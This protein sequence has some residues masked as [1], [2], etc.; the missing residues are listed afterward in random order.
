MKYQIFE[1]D[2]KIVL[3]KLIEDGVQ[4]DAVVTDPPYGLRFMNRKWDYD[5][6]SVEFWE[7]VLKIL[8][9]GGHVLSFGGTRTYH[10]MVVN[11]EDA[12]FEIRDQIVWMYG[13]GFPKSM[14]IG[15]SID[16]AAG[17][18]RKIVGFDETRFRANRTYEGGAKHEESVEAV[19]VGHGFDRRDNGATIT[20]PAT[21]EAI[22]WQGW[23]TALKPAI[24]PIVLARKPLEEPTVAANV[25]K[26]GT[27]G[28]NIDECRVKTTD[29]LGGGATSSDKAVIAIEGFDRPWMHDETKLK[30][31]QEKM[32]KNVV[33]AE[34]LGRFPA[35][36]ILDEEAGEM[37]DE[38]T[39]IS[40]SPTKPVKQGGQKSV[41]GIMNNVGGPRHGFGTG[42]G[43]SGDASRFFYC[44][45][46]SKKDRR[47][48]KHPTIKP[49]AL[50]RYLCRLITPPGGTVLDP[51]AGSGTTGEA[52]A[53]E[54]FQSILIE[55]EAEYIPDIE[56]RLGTTPEAPKASL[57]DLF[58]EN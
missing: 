42:F 9:P 21:P 47:G 43:D 7:L 19:Y 8:K 5:V 23:G 35:N 39:G 36:V 29:K 53:L 4:V 12:G 46:A 44:A 33:K 17:V 50:M 11:L 22:Q 1:G 6:P 14:N 45:K 40:T 26:H 38:Q 10:R 54:G 25:L 2:N 3:Q 13:S 58:E 15:K 48:S 24:E 30:E 41:G 56:K 31:H 55:R 28:I 27:G 57:D 49:L 18:E 32:R 16:K 37:L 34:S 52:A 51:F 20:T